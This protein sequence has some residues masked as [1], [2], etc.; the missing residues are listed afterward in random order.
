MKETNK[1]YLTDTSYITNFNN[2]QEL[3]SNLYFL[4]LNWNHVENE[5]TQA[6]KRLHMID[7][8]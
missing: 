4:I 7:L 1:V 5:L 6:Y 2:Q 8:T 3:Y